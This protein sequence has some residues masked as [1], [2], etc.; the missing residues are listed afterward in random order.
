MCM[1]PKCPCI[2]PPMPHKDMKYIT[3]RERS[4]IDRVL[5]KSK[6][7]EISKTLLKKLKYTSRPPS[8]L[9]Y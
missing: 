5:I 9:Q 1:G 6:L 3:F 8:T 7:N 2:Y 4:P